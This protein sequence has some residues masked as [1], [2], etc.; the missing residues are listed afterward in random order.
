[1]VVDFEL[2]DV[3]GTAELKTTA[4]QSRS[5]YHTDTGRGVFNLKH[6]I[7]VERL[8]FSLLLLSFTAYAVR[9]MTRSV[10]FPALTKLSAISYLKL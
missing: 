9:S 4:N 2:E 3:T 1:M 8:L 10:V 5:C 6:L 7:R